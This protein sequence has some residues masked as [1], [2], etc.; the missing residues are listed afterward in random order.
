MLLLTSW[1]APPAANNESFDSGG[2]RIAFEFAT[3]LRC[4]AK[5]YVKLVCCIKEMIHALDSNL[6]GKLGGVL[7][8]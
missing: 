7:W 6:V 3:A 5:R 2:R 1:Y 4:F 8:W